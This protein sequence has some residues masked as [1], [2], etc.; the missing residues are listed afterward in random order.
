MP[1]PT[2][3]ENLRSR[4][5]R[6]QDQPHGLHALNVDQVTQ[7]FR[8]LRK[9]IE[10]EAL[11]DSHRTAKFFAD[12]L[13]HNQLNSAVA[14]S[15]IERLNLEIGKHGAIDLVVPSALGL[16]ELRGELIDI[17][18]RFDIPDALVQTASVWLRLGSLLLEEIAGTPVSFSQDPGNKGKIIETRQRIWDASI[19]AYGDPGKGEPMWF[20]RFIVEADDGSDNFMWRLEFFSQTARDGACAATSTSRTPDPS[21]SMTSI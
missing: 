17:F 6:Y 9:L 21:G 18:E 10:K 5:V 11:Q 1:F 14:L 3:A 4:I 16:N 12:W 20:D 2:P 7:I 19:A 13:Q 8:Q 15:L